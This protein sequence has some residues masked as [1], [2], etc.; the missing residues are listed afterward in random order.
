MN[1]FNISNPFQQMPILI[2]VINILLYSF[3][4]AAAMLFLF[5]RFSKIRIPLFIYLIMGT[6]ELFVDD[7]A[8]I[9]DVIRCTAAIALIYYLAN[10]NH[11]FSLTKIV[12]YYLYLYAVYLIAMAFVGNAVMHIVHH[13]DPAMHSIWSQI[14][15]AFETVIIF[16]VTWLIL[17]VTKRITKTYFKMVVPY[18][19]V[20]SWGLGISIFPIAFFDFYVV[21]YHQVVLPP[22][23]ITTVFA[24]YLP[25]L[26]LTMWITGKYYAAQTE[27]SVF[28]N[29]L[30]NLQTYTSYI[31]TLYDDVRR[32]R[33][34]YKNILYTLSQQ[35]KDHDL[36]GAQ[37]LL[38][39]MTGSLGLSVSEKY[40]NISHLENVE[41]PAVK[42]LI[43]Y[44]ITEYLEQGIKV[45]V[46]VEKPIQLTNQ[47]EAL[48]LIRLLSILLDNAAQAAKDSR[49]KQ[50]A[51]SLFTKDHSQYVVVGNSTKAK[52]INLA[53]VE[54]SSRPIRWS[55]NHGLGLKNV[56]AILSQYPQA[57]Q[58]TSSKDYWF[59]QVIRIQ[60]D[61]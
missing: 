47:I 11:Q 6:F 33:H 23:L 21:L 3:L 39:K 50:V 20:W 40:S 12:S 17:K 37:E 56:K 42:S 14:F 2:W 8:I 7:V 52:A 30:N 4:D 24:A 28:H 61:H 25:L 46:E 57:Q 48:D 41:D 34:D 31:E 54:N 36:K 49:D 32:F 13:F 16:F 44:K 38:N 22:A 19:Y 60:V 35:L 27:N 53:A 5:Q 26:W 18:H 29:E 59:E 15:D 1:Y 58:L 9:N 45:R 43:F 10:P 55:A 51:I